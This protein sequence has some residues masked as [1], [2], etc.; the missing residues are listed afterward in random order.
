MAAA[1]GALLWGSTAAASPLIELSGGVSGQG[2]LSGRATGA[3]AA[4][5]YFNPALL[6]FA[7][8]SV[9][10]GLLVM[11]DHIGITLDGRPSG[12]VPDIVGERELVGADGKPIPNITAPTRWLRRGCPPDECKG[13]GFLARPR[14]ADGSSGNTR[15]Y[16]MIGLVSHVVKERLVVGFYALVPLGSFTTARAFYNDEREQFFSNSLHPE[17]YS[18]RMTATSLAFGVG[19]KLA[20][21]LSAGLSFTLNL[22][23]SAVA[24]TYVR[25]AN[26]Y[27]QL[28]LTT[29][30]DVQASVSP[31]FALRFT[32]TDALALSAVVHSKQEF[33]INTDFKAL[34][35]SG[36]ESRTSRT[37]VHDFLPWT[38]SLGASYDLVKSD[39][40]K[41]SA[42]ATGS[43]ALWSYY[44]DRHGESPAT[45]GHFLA[46][47]NTFS[48]SAGARIESGPLRFLV[49]ASYTPTPVPPQIGRSNY[50]DNDRF[51]TMLGAD[52]SFDA[53]G[54]KLRAG[55]SGEAHMLLHRHQLKRDDLIQDELPNDA[56]TV[57]G[58]PVPGRAGLQTNNPGW[59][60]FASQGAIL[61]AA[62]T[63]S[64]IY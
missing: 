32:P 9:E 58:T 57:T 2:G 40:F 6:P 59:P 48:G 11:S 33:I 5:T 27:N 4:S 20:D 10:L 42:V 22:R 46:W 49:D 62:A 38:F 50:V 56:Q 21:R 28:L 17:L 18:D 60:G 29:N 16:Q 35:P 39:K 26:D 24:G 54:L 53:L 37:S 8:Q 41:A 52:Y 61:G 12:D 47:K 45:F 13:E 63:I 51:G 25:D 3:S 31:H 43:Y 34:L 19:S 7:S 23:N 55:V 14:Q 44:L 1:F 15:A 30:V 36:L 64:V